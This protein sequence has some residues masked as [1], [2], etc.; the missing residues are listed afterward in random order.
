MNVDTVSPLLLPVLAAVLVFF[1]IAAALL[2]TV[3]RRG[4]V[5]GRV[6]SLAVWL[7][8]SVA[9][10]FVGYRQYGWASVA[11]GVIA[12]GLSVVIVYAVA[13]WSVGRPGWPADALA[14][15]LAALLATAALPVSLLMLLAALG[16]DGP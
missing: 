2:R 10:V 7:V 15:C 4:A 9:V 12:V 1:A 5:Q 16:V 14:V 6:L 3:A 13:R 8:G 11:P